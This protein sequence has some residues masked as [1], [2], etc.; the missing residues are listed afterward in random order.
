MQNETENL[1]KT[2]SK[3]SILTPIETLFSKD[4]KWLSSQAL[5]KKILTIICSVNF[6]GDDTLQFSQDDADVRDVVKYL[7]HS[8]PPT[9]VSNNK[10]LVDTFERLSSA[11]N[12]ERESRLEQAFS[13]NDRWTRSKQSPF[14]DDPLEDKI[15]RTEDDED[16]YEF[17][18]ISWN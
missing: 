7:E 6:H 17:P 2:F 4:L 14:E 3:E 10:L 15:F 13:N 18:R 16:W 1:N 9:L 12:A 8:T 11:L 5:S